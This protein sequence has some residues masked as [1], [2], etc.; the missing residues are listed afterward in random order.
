M[1]KL[2]HSKFKNTGILFELLTRQ[3]TADI[4]A[5]REESPAKNILFRYFAE[6]KE[7]GKEWQLYHFLLNEKAMCV[8]GELCL[9]TSANARAP[10]SVMPVL[11]KVNSFKTNPPF[12]KAAAIVLAPSSPIALVPAASRFE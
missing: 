10:S 7:L 12:A 5:N 8:R 4:L 1:S 9:S 3:I 2:K 6:N 11:Q